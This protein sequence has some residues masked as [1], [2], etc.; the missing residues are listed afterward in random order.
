MY[1]CQHPMW[2]LWA[3][4]ICTK[5]CFSVN[6]LCTHTPTS[7]QR[8]PPY[9]NYGQWDHCVLREYKLPV[10]P[11]KTFLAQRE[12]NILVKPPPG[13]RR[14]RVVVLKFVT[15]SYF[16]FVW[17]DFTF[18][19]TNWLKYKI[20]VSFSCPCMNYL[21]I[22]TLPP[23]LYLCF[24]CCN[25]PLSTVNQYSSTLS[26]WVPTLA[27]CLGQSISDVIFNL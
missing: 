13:S 14:G 23:L 11:C 15:K 12:G 16:G 18:M 5:T 8:H 27:T 22:P 17:D 21:V 10:H 4:L 1:I 26:M 19:R 7:L 2:Y 9:C 3:H 25:L 24:L 6:P 20:T